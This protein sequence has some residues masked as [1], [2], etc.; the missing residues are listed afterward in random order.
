MVTS[1]WG[2]MRIADSHVH[3]F[4]QQFFKLLA[5]QKPG[6]TIDQMGPALGW[7]MP[8]EDP[9]ALARAWVH[10]LDHHGVERAALIASLPGDEDSVA[11][12]VAAYPARFWGYFM[13]N[14]HASDVVVRVQ[15]ALDRGLHAV[16]FFP[17]MHRYHMHD[18]AAMTLLDVVAA[19]RPSALVFVHCGV[20]SVGVRPKLGLASPFDMRYSNPVDLHGIALRFPQLRFIIPHFGAG[21]LREA[22]MVAELC[23]NVFLDTSSSNRWMDYEGLDL[24]TVFRRTLD[25]LGAR[26]LLFGTDSSFFP[27]GWNSAIFEAQAKALYE[28]GLEAKE[29][30]YIFGENLRHLLSGA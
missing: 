13:V 20:L 26:R 27:R 21:F 25:L 9:V 11:A 18:E 10:D 6:L 28:L 24:R 14:P 16:C 23:P 15:G 4:S 22:L 29:A 17:A 12:A 3:F 7:Q 19:T 8:P 30:G 1:P 5:A 2:P